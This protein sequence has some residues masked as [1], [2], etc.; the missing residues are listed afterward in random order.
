[1]AFNICSFGESFQGFGCPFL[2]GVFEFPWKLSTMFP[3]P[4]FLHIILIIYFLYSFG[5]TIPLDGLL[6]SMM[7]PNKMNT[8][9]LIVLFWFLEILKIIFVSL[10]QVELQP[11][12]AQVC[13]FDRFRKNCC[14]Q[15]SVRETEGEG[16]YSFTAKSN[17]QTS[18]GRRSHWHWYQHRWR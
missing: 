7:Y 1:M 12:F 14:S 10:Y 6:A 11:W 16:K 15:R 8:H 5:W 18:W 2:K 17:A 9:F 13:H 3:P 4:P